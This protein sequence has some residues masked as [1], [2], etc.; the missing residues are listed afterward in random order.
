M[1]PKKKIQPIKEDNDLK[2]K[3][4]AKREGKPDWRIYGV[5]K[6]E[7]F[8][9][10]E[11]ELPRPISTML[12][13][14]GGC[15]AIFSPPGSG[16]S[17]MVS[18]LLLR[19]ELLKDMFLG[20]LYI[21]SPTIDNDLTS[22]HLKKYAD[23]TSTQFSETLVEAIFDNIMTIPNDERELSCLLLDDCLGQIKQHSFMNRWASTVRHLRNLCIFS[24]QA[25][26]GLPPTVRSNVSHTITFYQPSTKQLNDIVELHSNMGGE[27]NFRKCYEEATGQKYGFLL[28]DWRDM[29]MYKWGSDL[30]E[31]IE[32]WSR[33]D[34]NGNINKDI[35]KETEEK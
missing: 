19:E 25:L 10:I 28:C 26:K 17:N 8:K 12:E 4:K 18:N 9:Q 14:G 22:V 33:Y 24:L 27:E 31:P 30:P 11:R 34:E 7:E 35:S 5:R 3:M 13:K 23:F 16:K 20:G 1:P 15:L 21:I 2:R 29:K 32:I 6:E